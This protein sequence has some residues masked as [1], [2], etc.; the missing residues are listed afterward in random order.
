M[1]DGRVP[2]VLDLLRWLSVA[3]LGIFSGAM[4]TEGG[5]LVP[6]WRALPPAEFL[7]W[8]AANA[9]RLLAFFSPVTTAAGVLALLAAAGSLWE[10]HPGRWW[11]V[12]AAVLMVAVVATFF[13]YFEAVNASFAAATIAGDAVPAE[14]ARWA[15]WHYARTAAS[16]LALA[17]ALVAARS[18]A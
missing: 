2:L 13:V 5:V 12:A 11:T 17:A 10:G 1:L 14:L 3:A 9:E 8:Y 16:V 15:A 18:T 7:R 4:L 6:Y